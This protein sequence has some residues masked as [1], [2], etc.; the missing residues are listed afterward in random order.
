MIETSLEDF[1]DIMKALPQMSEISMPGQP[2]RFIALGISIIVISM[3]LSM[4][5]KSHNWMEKL[6]NL[7]MK[8]DLLVDIT[9]LHEAPVC[10]LEEKRTRQI[11]YS[12]M[13]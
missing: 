5:I 6:Q 3:I 4:L 9:H 10:H 1:R 8:T 11:S 12:Q 13:C 7:K 2:K